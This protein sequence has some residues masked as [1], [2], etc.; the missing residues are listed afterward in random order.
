M[1]PPAKPTAMKR[2]R[3]TADWNNSEKST[4]N[5]TNREAGKRTIKRRRIDKL[6]DMDSASP[7]SVCGEMANEEPIRME[8]VCG[9]TAN[10]EPISLES[11]CGETANE[12]SISMEPVCGETAK[13]CGLWGNGQ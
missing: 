4:E 12:E 6:G 2:N 5:S 7:E 1:N 8:S 13:V 11:V 10:E 9:E 3:V